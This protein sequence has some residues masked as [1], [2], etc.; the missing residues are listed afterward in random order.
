MSVSHLTGRCEFCGRERR[1]ADLKM[2][3]DLPGKRFCKTDVTV[4]LR[5]GWAPNRERL[6]RVEGQ[7]HS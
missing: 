5:L 3:A 6:A 7:G 2:D 1:S 4:C